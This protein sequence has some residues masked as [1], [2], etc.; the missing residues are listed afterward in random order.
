MRDGC[1]AVR[2]VRERQKKGG[3]INQV[4]LGSLPYTG[5]RV[6]ARLVDE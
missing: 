6:A 4:V 1:E 5:E 2:P 3:E